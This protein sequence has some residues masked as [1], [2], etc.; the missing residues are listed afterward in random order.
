MVRPR[1][2]MEKGMGLRASSYELR[3]S[4]FE[5]RASSLRNPHPNLAQNAGL[6]WG[7]RTRRVFQKSALCWDQQ[8]DAPWLVARGSKLAASSMRSRFE[9]EF[10]WWQTVISG[11]FLPQLHSVLHFAQL[12]EPVN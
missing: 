6:G 1:A 4:S 5:L 10:R 9:F 7:T 12:L 11:S 3:A 8:F 2:K